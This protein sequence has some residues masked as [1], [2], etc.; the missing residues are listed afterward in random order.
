ML[1]IV[2]CKYSGKDDNKSKVETICDLL[3]MGAN[4]SQQEVLSQNACLHWASYFTEEE[5]LVKE[6]IGQGAHVFPQDRNRLHP[7]D[8]IGTRVPPPVEQRGK[9]RKPKFNKVGVAF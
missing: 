5:E 7:I 3:Y 4:P 2:A 9:R 8:I 6:L 1:N